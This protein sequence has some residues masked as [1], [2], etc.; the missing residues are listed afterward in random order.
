MPG[1]TKTSRK[2]YHAP[3]FRV[4]QQLAMDDDV[5]ICNNNTLLEDLI[6]KR[7]IQKSKKWC[8][9]VSDLRRDLA[10]ASFE[11]LKN[12]YCSYCGK[13]LIINNGKIECPDHNDTFSFH[14]VKPFKL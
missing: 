1:I 9:T 7:K 6:D 14:T 11:I 12:P 4:W 5:T 2:T 13:V 10:I 8:R 3:Q